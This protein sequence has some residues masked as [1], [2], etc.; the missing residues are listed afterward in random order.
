MLSIRCA[1]AD[2]VELI[3]QFI[4]DLAEYEREP[5]AV[6]AT[7]EDLIR[8]G[9]SDRPKFHVLIA[10][11][12]KQPAGFAFYFFNYSTWRGK[13]GLH[14]EDLF[15]QPE[16]REKGIGK[17]LLAE[18]AEIAVQENCYGLRW[19]VLDWNTPAI[20]FYERV[21][22]EVLRHWLPVRL[23]GQPLLRLAEAASGGRGNPTG[24]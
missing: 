12:N 19:E 22:G 7:R 20:D 3:L 8:D 13:S 2:D 18:L 11:W 21:G 14:L 23:T 10:D 17:A 24:C 9:F 15:V 1:T 5:Q 16:Y 4:H 6:V